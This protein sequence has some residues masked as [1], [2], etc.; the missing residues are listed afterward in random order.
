MQFHMS[1]SMSYRMTESRELRLEHLQDALDESTKSKALDKAMGFTLRMRGN[2]GAYRTG[3]IAEL[4]QL[5]EEQGSVTAAE[6]AAVLDTPQVPVE[7]ESRWSVG[8]TDE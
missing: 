8:D 2:S 4:M 6:I 3:A 7:H 5:A 1:N